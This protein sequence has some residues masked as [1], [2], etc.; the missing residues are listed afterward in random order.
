MAHAEDD[1]Q[2]GSEMVQA[3]ARAQELGRRRCEMLELA[4]NRGAN[5]C[6]MGR[7]PEG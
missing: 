6:C 5:Y 1:V 4:A 3:Q 7:Q 2:Q